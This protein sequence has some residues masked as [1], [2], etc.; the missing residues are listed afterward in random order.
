MG[1]SVIWKKSGRRNGQK[2]FPNI[3]SR[4]I[5]HPHPTLS[6]KRK[7]ERGRERDGTEEATETRFCQRWEP[8]HKQTPRCSHT[9][10]ASTSPESL[11]RSQLISPLLHFSLLGFLLSISLPLVLLLWSSLPLSIS[12]LSFSLSYSRISL[13][14]FWKYCEKF[15]RFF[16]Q[17]IVKHILGYFWKYCEKNSVFFGKILWKHILKIMCENP[18]FFCEK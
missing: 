13:K 11:S 17:N 2:G 1:R 6:C 5:I 18:A 3:S 4:P 16:P 12:N 9:L 7:M 10:P 14:I 15:L 8:K